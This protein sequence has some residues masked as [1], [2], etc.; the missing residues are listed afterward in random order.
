MNGPKRVAHVLLTEGDLLLLLS[1]RGR[2]TG[3]PE[4]AVPIN[5]GW[6]DRDR[7]FW[8]RYYDERFA[9]VEE[10]GAIPILDAAVEERP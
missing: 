10:C 1:G 9:P 5:V 6:S 2:L 3:V 7:R 4:G 8:V